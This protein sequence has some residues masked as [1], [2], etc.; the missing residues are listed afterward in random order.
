MVIFQ[1]TADDQF[2]KNIYCLLDEFHYRIVKIFKQ[3]LS[4][5][6]GGKTIYSHLFPSYFISHIYK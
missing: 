2:H 6:Q 1:E 4:T 5:T 3:A